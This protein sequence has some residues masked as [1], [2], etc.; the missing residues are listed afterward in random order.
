M[1]FPKRDHVV[2]KL[3]RARDVVEQS[4]REKI[5]KEINEFDGSTIGVEIP[6]DL[7]VSRLDKIV[8]DLQEDGWK[9]KTPAPRQGNP[10]ELII[11]P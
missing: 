8:A 6:E 2:D 1:G 10:A 4:F 5:I 7:H 3:E 9:V 11:N